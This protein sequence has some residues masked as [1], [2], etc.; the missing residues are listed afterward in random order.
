MAGQSTI[1]GAL[2]KTLQ[3]IDMD[4]QVQPPQSKNQVAWQER[5]PDA[6]FPPSP[7]PPTENLQTRSVTTETFPDHTPK[8]PTS[9]TFCKSVEQP[10]QTEILQTIIDRVPVM[11]VFYDT[12]TNATFF[13][14]E[15]KRLTG[16]SPQHTDDFDLMAACY[17]NE[18]YRKEACQFMHRAE[19]VW[20][21]FEVTTRWNTTLHTAWTHVR[22]SDGFYMAIGID[23]G[24]RKHL[25]SDLDQRTRLAERRSEQLRDLWLDLAENAQ[26]QKRQL[27]LFLHEDLQQVLVAARMHAETVK[28]ASN[29]PSTKEGLTELQNL[30]HQAVGASRTCTCDIHPPVIYAGGLHDALTW[31]TKKMLQ[32]HGLHVELHV[33]DQAN[34]NNE[35]VKNLLFNAIQELLR[36]I[37]QHAGVTH[38]HV[39][40]TRK[41]QQLH[42]EV[43][44]QGNG[45]DPAHLKSKGG[46][47]QG[48]GLFGIQ[49]KLEFL[50]GQLEINSSP[51]QGS[52]FVLRA[53]L[54]TLADLDT[55]T[56]HLNQQNDPRHISAPDTLPHN[57]PLKHTPQAIRVLLVDDHRI[58]LRGLEALLRN[59]PDLRVVGQASNGRE[60][61]E[62]ARQIKP[63]VI[64][65]DVAMPQ[66]NGIEATRAIK[67]EMPDIRIVGLSMFEDNE[68]GS[69]MRQAGA[70]AFLNKAG[71]T[72]A[73]LAA[74]RD[75]HNDLP[76]HQDQT[77]L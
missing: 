8:S 2:K 6:S 34:T 12:D 66:M 72:E 38:A 17:P 5:Q 4:Q 70:N 27:A 50:N 69:Q 7:A 52:R 59:E 73:L 35:T 30:L 40:V 65:M 19:P 26:H 23:V 47:A 42:V 45:F 49:E 63:Q 9:E 3:D 43:C 61:L 46:C 15:F 48:F 76:H 67:T 71:P 75:A 68:M 51:G 10:L 55:N 24:Q 13:N 11:L 20:R 62:L 16:Y 53:P 60:A 41:N 37:V 64:L 74:I 25:E 56:S 18:V 31:L 29:D 54:G 44:D 39:N 36:N 14:H 22:L 32:Q 77:D 1:G 57:E 33:Q 58:V 28:A 21:D